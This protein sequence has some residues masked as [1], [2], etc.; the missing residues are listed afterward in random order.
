ML[1]TSQLQNF[2]L[3]AGNLEA[4]PALLLDT[5]I[6]KDSCKSFRTLLPEV[7]I[8]YAFKSFNDPLVVSAIDGLVDGYDVASL[9]EIESL[10][11]GGVHAN[12]MAFSNPVK[13]SDAIA[14]ANELGI[15]KFSFQSE[16]ELIKLSKHAP[17]SRVY[18]RLNVNGADG[19]LDFSSKFGADPQKA[20]E[21]LQQASQLGLVPI[22]ITFHVGSQAED[23][24]A[25]KA[26]IARALHIMRTI[27]DAGIVLQELNIGGGFPVKYEHNSL[28]IATLAPV[29][30]EALEQ[31]KAEFPDI[32]IIAEPGRF[33]GADSAVIVSTVIGKEDRGGKTWL[34]MDTGNFQ[35]FTEVFE[36]G[37]FLH[38]VH[39]LNDVLAG[40]DNPSLVT[41]ALTGP[42]C[43]SFDTMTQSI[44]L[45]VGIEVGDKL[46]ITMAGSYTIA[47]GSNFNGFAPP[48]VNILNHNK[49]DAK[50]PA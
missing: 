17:G 29:L 39:T 44:E 2:A 32:Q 28:T 10:L 41:Y 25:W 34:Y 47:Y 48:E 4:S 35:S 49:V 12:R 22:G 9:T 13:S 19:A 45:P 6:L 3:A 40:N 36:F 30:N 18:V 33:I 20:V 21:L 8:F 26:A 38:P 37:R 50:V 27:A 11:A 43:D 24:E 16:N 23:I 15:G 46:L 31:V 7:Q 1:L 5:T 42:T 14:R